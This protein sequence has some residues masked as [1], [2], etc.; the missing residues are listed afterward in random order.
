MNNSNLKSKSRTILTCMQHNKRDGQ[1]I[2]TIF[3]SGCLLYSHPLV[4]VAT[5]PASYPFF[6]AMIFWKGVTIEG[7]QSVVGGTECL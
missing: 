6:T 4:G 7:V 5:I 2:H 1:S 3:Y